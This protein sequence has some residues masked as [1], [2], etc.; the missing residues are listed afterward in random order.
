M[1]DWFGLYGLSVLVW[2]VRRGRGRLREMFVQL[3][4]DL[5][6]CLVIGIWFIQVPATML[7]VDGV[8]KLARGFGQP[9]WSLRD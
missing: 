5:V 7:Q 1:S 9:Y 8:L 3:I 2:L 4:V 6:H